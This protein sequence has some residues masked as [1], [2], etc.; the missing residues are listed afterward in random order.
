[1]RSSRT[2]GGIFMCLYVGTTETHSGFGIYQE[3][4][5]KNPVGFYFKYVI[6]SFVFSL[7]SE[8]DV[9]VSYD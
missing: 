5:Q 7:E 3:I 8:S 1:M 2:Q 4:L 9:S 6:P